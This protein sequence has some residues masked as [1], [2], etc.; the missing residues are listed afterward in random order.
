M[1]LEKQKLDI[2]AQYVDIAIP[3]YTI[4]DDMCM[5]YPLIS[6]VP[7]NTVDIEFTDAI[8]QDIVS[9]LKKLHSI[10]LEKFSFLE[11]KKGTPE[12]EKEGLKFFVNKLK[13]KVKLRLQDKVPDCVIENI[14]QYMDTL[15]FVYESPKKAFVH[16]D[17][18]AKN[19]IYDPAQKK[20]S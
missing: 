5:T 11:I 10:P 4:L 18:Q 2:I 19:I 3:Q 14:Y 9:F 20:I 1:K 17:I 15:F 7:L 13:D 12:E 16:S 6:G 8:I